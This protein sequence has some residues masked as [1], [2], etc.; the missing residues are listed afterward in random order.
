[1]QNGRAADSPGAN[2][3][4]VTEAQLAGILSIA[5]DAIITVDEA[6][7]IILFNKGAERI[8]GYAVEEV[9]GQPLEMLLPLGARSSHAAHIAEFGASGTAARRMGERSEIA[10]RRRDGSEFPADASI[11]CF[12]TGARR[13]YT[14]ILR[15]VTEQKRQAEALNNAKRAAELAGAA[16][17]MF[18]ANMS[19]EIRTPLNAII[20]M[21]SLLLY[22]DLADE[23]RDFVQTIR[24]SGDSLLTIINEILDYTKIELGSLELDPHPF[25]VR[26]VVEAC[27]D[28]VAGVAAEKNLNLAYIADDS[29]P[30]VV[31]SDGLR[32]RQILLNILSNAVKFTRQGEVVVN[33]EAFRTGQA[34]YELH[35]SVV[36]T[37]IGIREEERERIFKP[38]SQV[39]ASTTREYGGTGLGL[40]ISQRLCEMLGGR[41]WVESI[42]GRG[43][44]FRFT[45]L[46]EQGTELPG[47]HVRGAEPQLAGKRVLIV[48][49]I[50]TN[51]RILVKHLRKWGMLP[52]AV[53]SALEALDLIRDGHAFNLA[54]LDLSMPQMDG[55]Q[56]AR[57][58]R[59]TRDAQA[60]PLVLLT[61][62][63]QRQK[64]VEA[65]GVEFSAYLHK[66][67]KPSQLLDI[68]MT[69]IGGG[70]QETADDAGRAAGPGLAM[71][72][73]LHILLAE[74]NAVNQ[75]VVLRMLAHL[76]YLADTAANG[77][78][79]LAALERRS[80]D[81]VLM[82]IQMPEMDG[83]DTTRHIL[84][85]YPSGSRPYVIAM[86]ANALHGD[87]ERFMAAGMDDYLSKPI[88]ME[89]MAR[90]LQRRPQLDVPSSA[91]R[92]GVIDL[93]QLQRLRQL[94]QREGTSLFNEVISQFLNEVP[95]VGGKMTASAQQGDGAALADLAHSLAS[96][97][98]ACGARRVADVCVMLERAG[99]QGMPSVVPALLQRLTQEYEQVRSPLIE[100]QARARVAPRDGK[101][102]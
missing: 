64:Q 46:A 5:D 52:Q 91:L 49:D 96:T 50:A 45:M 75:K 62:M 29:V 21:T 44:T 27:L 48:D 19:H 51:R 93:A 25:D 82:D 37:G 2:M 99:K 86:T 36:D 3:S 73:P 88:D 78:E 87:R 1:M 71:Q 12:D 13:I 10:G 74:D 22:A 61:S 84:E 81:V 79:V 80:Y 85:R 67:I 33:V 11:S 59:K 92:P 38:F 6:Q 53:G 39:D 41:I 4:V 54:I 15:D 23:Q 98:L 101:Q 100:E 70:G 97:A 66:P 94:D 8:F 63:G 7:R 60:L 42:P 95:D 20:G 31:V 18:L 83:I 26:H 47:T 43:S 34:S 16:K 55:V 32:L 24:T 77:R 69:L 57:A 90:A 89:E 30:A 68:L 72:L 76:G 17:S 102:E 40:A 58:I 9:I 56:L 35:F 14:A 65:A 28:Q